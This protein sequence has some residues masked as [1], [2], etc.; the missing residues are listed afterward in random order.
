MQYYTISNT[1]LSPTG[2]LPLWLK[3]WELYPRAGVPKYFSAVRAT[4]VSLAA[5]IGLRR[6]RAPTR[7]TAEN[8]HPMGVER[9][10]TFVNILHHW[11][12]KTG[13]WLRHYVAIAPPQG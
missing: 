8:V 10:A 11:N 4:R 1:Y 12:V 2:T 7:T 13:T 6:R 9:A 5:L 3:F